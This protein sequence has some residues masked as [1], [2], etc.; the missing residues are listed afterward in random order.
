MSWDALADAARREARNIITKHFFSGTLVT[1]G[2][3]PEKHVVKGI[4]VPHGIE[5]DWIPIGNHHVGKDFGILVGPK[6]GDPKKL[7]GDLFDIEFD[8]GDL[9]SPIARMRIHNSKDK[10][11]KVE[12]GEMLFKHEKGMSVFFDKD[13]NATYTGSKKQTITQDKDGHCVIKLD[14]GNKFEL[15][16]DGSAAIYDKDGKG[17]VFVDGGKVHLGDKNASAMVLTIQGPAKNVL[18]KV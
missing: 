8:G 2:Y 3:D 18:A 4:I 14:G 15:K 6:V 1:T 5:T 16:K 11:P 13:E 10:P 12:S 7:D 9:S 17:I